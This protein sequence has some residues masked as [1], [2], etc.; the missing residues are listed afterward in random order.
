MMTQSA[1]IWQEGDRWY[2]AIASDE[3]VVLLIWSED[4]NQVTQD[5]PDMDDLKVGA[6]ARRN[7][8]RLRRELHEY[9]QGERKK[10]TVQVASQGTKFQQEVWKALS[11]I[12][13][14]KCITYGELAE[15]IGKPK[16]SRAVGQAAGHNPVPII[17][18]CHRL[19]AADGKIGGFGRGVEGGVEEKKRL[20][21][22]EGV[23]PDKM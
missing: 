9:H 6:A 12:P 21:K 14:G 16:A 10:F 13:Y 3:G 5:L 11:G 2:G 18:P 1:M 23:D 20:L 4:R 19:I 17:I 15:Q 8:E 22:H 7:L